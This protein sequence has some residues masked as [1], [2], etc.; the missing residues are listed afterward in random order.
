MITP[1][2]VMKYRIANMK[3]TIFFINVK[4]VTKGMNTVHSL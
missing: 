3:T 1:E 4:I 2:V